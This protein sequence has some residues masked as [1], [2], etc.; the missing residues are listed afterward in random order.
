MTKSA[1]SFLCLI[2]AVAFADGAR[3]QTRELGSSGEL[4]DGIA[5]L[6]NRGVVLKSDLQ[7]RLNYV[8]DNFAQQ[9][10]QLPPDQRGQ[11]PP[12]SVL[13][14]QV[15]D[16]L[17]LEEIQVQRAETIGI[18]IGDDSLNG[19][20]AEI[21]QGAGVSLEQFPDWLE[22]QGI[23]YPQF[24]DDQRRDTMIR[25]LERVEVVEQIMIN[26]RELEQ[27]LSMSQMSEV[28]EFDYN[29]SHILIGFDPDGPSEQIA[30]AEAKIRDIARQL[31]EGADFT[32]LAIAYSESATA[33]EGGNLGWRKGSELPTIFARDVT[34]LEQ[35]EHSAPIRGGG[36]FHIVKLNE[37]RG[38][39]RE[40]VDQIHARHILLAPTE[41]L[42]DDATRQRLQG[43]RDQ[44]LGGD[45]FATVASAVSEDVASAVDGGDLG[46]TSLDAFVPEFSDVLASLE[47]GELSQPFRTPYG[48]H[49]AEVT[50]QR[51]Y[52]MTDERRENDC[53]NQ[54]GRGKAVEEIELWRRRMQSEAYIVK[55]I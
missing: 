7:T 1:I 20:L 40:L 27:C 48:W 42:D 29:I 13:E 32:Q 2:L 5:A 22:S 31:D 39:E 52:D 55:K 21:A 3:A 54:I 30:E 16:Q 18:E 34:E 14:Q 25:Q 41:V 6:V 17:I 44:I 37:V 51:V 9:Q 15:L 50:D 24:R 10:A 47:I 4:L 36:G 45:D 35:G 8:R 49:I 53:R 33:L 46:W 19:M 38:V 43:I 26:P 23:N 28:N 11:L 12:L